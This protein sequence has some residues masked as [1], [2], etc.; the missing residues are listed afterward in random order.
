MWHIDATEYYLAL[1]SKEILTYTLRWIKTW[2]KAQRPPNRIS[3]TKNEQHV[4]EYILY[5]LYV[6][7]SI[8][9]ILIYMYYFMYTYI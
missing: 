4:I 8:Y 5:M 1:K 2:A 9:I 3:E 6:T 7:D